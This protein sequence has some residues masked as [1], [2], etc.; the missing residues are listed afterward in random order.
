MSS[1]AT[2]AAKAEQAEAMYHATSTT[3]DGSDKHG[4]MD[5]NELFEQ[6]LHD[7]GGFGRFQILLLLSSLFASFLAAFNHLGPIYLAF[8]PEFEC[9][10]TG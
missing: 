2:A 1:D 10:E 8:T 6:I 4:E 5:K 7:L 3:E 9:V